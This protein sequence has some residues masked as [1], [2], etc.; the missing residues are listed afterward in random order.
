MSMIRGAI[1]RQAPCCTAQ[2]LQ[3]RYLSMNFSADAYWTDGWTVNSLMPIR[4][5]Y[6]RCLC[7]QVLANGDLVTLRTLEQNEFDYQDYPLRLQPLADEDWPDLVEQKRGDTGE[8]SARLYYWMLQNHPYREQYCA[9]REAEEAAFEAQWRAGLPKHRRAKMKYERAADRAI[10]VPSF[11]PSAGLRANLER[12]IELLEAE[13]TDERYVFANKLV[14]AY[15]EL[16]LFDQAKEALARIPKDSWWV[17]ERLLECL[18][19][20]RQN[21]LMR[22]RG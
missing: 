13:H 5:P 2:Y 16:S 3:P 15:R 10:S 8:R 12:L 19:D 11:T 6:Q 21:A 1:L 20:E 17:T 22:Y 7:G 18:I 4:A 9:H 14:E